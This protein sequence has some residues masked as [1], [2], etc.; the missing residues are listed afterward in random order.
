MTGL[1]A[2]SVHQLSTA[3]TWRS[4]VLIVEADSPVRNQL[5]VALEGYASGCEFLFAA[6]AVEA[7]VVLA[8]T[9]VD[10]LVIDLDLPGMGG[11]DLLERVRRAYPAVARV[12]LS[13]PDDPDLVMSA[14]GATHRYL[15][16]PCQPDELLE[17]LE[18]A[19]TARLVMGEPRLQALLGASS[20]LP[21]PP[22]IYAELSALVRRPDCST[23]AIA[24]VIQRDVAAATELLKLANSSF[25]GLPF[26][27][28]S[29]ERAVSLLGSDMVQSLVLAG[30]VFR[31]A[32]PVPD[33]LSAPALARRALETCA[34]LR[35]M[36][37]GEGWDEEVSGQL[38]LAGLLHDVGLLVLAA[39]SPS[40][41]TAYQGWRGESDQRER[42]LR[43]FGCTVGQASA[44]LLGLWGFD[45]AVVAVLAEQ[46]VALDDELAWV[47]PGALALARARQQDAPYDIDVAS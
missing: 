13:D 37:P 46:P 15:P 40:G 5:R 9:P 36:A 17:A 4:R 42:E 34:R 23:V 2:R 26:T 38:S 32:L 47:S 39:S 3:E 8:R 7:L 27:V 29:V 1:A 6:S 22:G 45:Q 41:W 14:A 31:P 24:Q 44:Y 43:A 25:F 16:K 10:V 30:A 19:L 11:I 18:G 28:T 33:G 35:A 20:S 12:V 21:K